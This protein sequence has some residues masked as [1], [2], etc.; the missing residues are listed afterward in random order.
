MHINETS[1][2]LTD[3][4]V[5]QRYGVHRTTVWR[6]VRS[7]SFPAPKPISDGCKRWA[8]NDIAAH[9]QRMAGEAR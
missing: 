1:F 7:G 9:E 3:K 8:D 6:W 5:A 4:Q 2:Y